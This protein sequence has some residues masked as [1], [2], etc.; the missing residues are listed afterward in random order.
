MMRRALIIAAVL[1]AVCGPLAA[2]PAGSAPAGGPVNQRQP[3]ASDLSKS[4]SALLPK[5]PITGKSPIEVEADAPLATI[6]NPFTGKADKI[7]LGKAAFQGKGCPG[8]HGGNGGGGMCPPITNDVWVYGSDDD[9]LFRLITLGSMGLEK[10]GFVRIGM[11]NIVGPMPPFGDLIKNDEELFEI[12]A[13]VR[14]LYK[15]PAN[16]INW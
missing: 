12:L 5:S 6:N 9:T 13:Y 8:C 15:G 10:K 4:P 14:S 11:E 2:D 1:T 3:S 16:R 7:E